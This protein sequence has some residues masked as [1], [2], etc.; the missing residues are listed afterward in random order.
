L[1][2]V[3]SRQEL[4]DAAEHVCYEI[5]MLHH[6]GRAL[7]YGLPGNGPILNAFINSFAI[8]VRNLVDF[9]YEKKP[10][11]KPDAILAEHYMANGQD[12]AKMR[13]ALTKKLKDAKIRCDKQVA[14]LTTR[15]QKKE[16]WNFAEIVREL[17]SPLAKFVNS[18][19][20]SLLGEHFKPIAH[21]FTVKDA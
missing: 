6:M 9:L 16:S 7:A 20:L 15:R 5:W 10:N 19:D 18:I 14:H 13:P 11:K 12:W 4:I 2:K 17:H 1:A 8:H 3:R 21:Y